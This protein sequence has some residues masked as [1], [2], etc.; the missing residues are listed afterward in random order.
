M[1]S[2][3]KDAR[4]ASVL[5][6]YRALDR[7]AEREAARGL[8]KPPVGILEAIDFPRALHLASSF[9]PASSESYLPLHQADPGRPQ[10]VSLSRFGGAGG[11]GQLT[12]KSWS[13]SVSLI[14]KPLSARDKA[15][16]I[17]ALI[18]HT[19]LLAMLW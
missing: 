4:E 12:V 2:G 11:P 1:E 14:R 19:H 10:Q 5:A 3:R 13:Q 18:N 8:W 16:T 17:L 9:P 7:G 15:L 6:F